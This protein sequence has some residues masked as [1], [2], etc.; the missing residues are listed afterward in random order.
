MTSV[1]G[2]IAVQDMTKVME[3]I[4]TESYEQVM[5]LTATTIAY[6]ILIKAAGGLLS[7]IRY[8]AEDN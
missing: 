2:F 8:G 1:L 5:I 7:R 4:R 6:F 3:I